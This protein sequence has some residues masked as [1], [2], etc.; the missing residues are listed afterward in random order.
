MRLPRRRRRSRPASVGS[1]VS[2]DESVRIYG[3]E[4]LHIGSNVR[5]DAFV[6]ISAGA[7]GVEIGDYVHIGAHS[8]IAGAGRV[9]ISSFVN[10]SGRVSIYSSNEDPTGETLIGPM[11][12][13]ELRD[14]IT[15][16]VSVGRHAAIGS[17]SVLLPGAALGDG[18][19]VAT[20]S[21]V[22]DS[23][24]AFT[25]VGGVPARPI[26]TRSRRMVELEQE[27]ESS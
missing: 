13:S 16:P 19:G 21:L 11:V 25:I 5:I 14:V 10:I 6:V 17:G 18:S 23:V 20:L 26:G 7:G 2:I 4:R 8:F 12:P 9:E 27:L 3:A 1:N 24:E 22:K 15:A